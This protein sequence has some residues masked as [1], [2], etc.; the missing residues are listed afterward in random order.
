GRWA[1]GRVQA[2][3]KLG[4]GVAR[5]RLPA[6]KRVDAL[7]HLTSNVSY[8]FLFAA[9]LLLPWTIGARFPAPAFLGATAAMAAFYA[10]AQRE[11]GG[12]ALAAL[13]RAPLVMAVCAGLACRQSPPVP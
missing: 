9:C 5:A 13:A 3:R 7:F 12:G 10:L 1:R 4:G 11:I 8:V 2:R 6:W